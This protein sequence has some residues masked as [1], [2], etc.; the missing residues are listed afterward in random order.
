MWYRGVVNVRLQFTQ[1]DLRE[2][3][4]QSSPRHRDIPIGSGLPRSFFVL[5]NFQPL[6]S[7]SSSLQTCQRSS[8]CRTSIPVR[9]LDLS[10]LFATL[11]KTAGCVPK[12]PNMEHSGSRRKGTHMIPVT[13]SSTASTDSSPLHCQH[14]SASGRRFCRLPISDP[15]SGLCSRHAAL[16]QKDLDQ[17]GLAASLPHRR[18]PGIP[19]RGRHQPFS[20][21]TL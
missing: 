14:R 15:D 20:R 9:C 18:H 19:L 1:S 5:F 13:S 7:F 3:H 6:T 17:A 4:R 21:R 16:L 2:G 12:V 11:T 8:L 10:P